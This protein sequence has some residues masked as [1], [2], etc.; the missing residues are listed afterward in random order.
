MIEV[1]NLTTDHMLVLKDGTWVGISSITN[2]IYRNS[3]LI[4]LKN[5]EWCCLLNS[6]KVETKF[7]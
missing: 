3:K 6:D 1:K 4:S 2:G 5:G 7:R